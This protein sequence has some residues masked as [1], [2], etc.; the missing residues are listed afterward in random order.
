MNKDGT[1]DVT[2]IKGKKLYESLMVE[3]NAKLG[4]FK[5]PE[6]IFGRHE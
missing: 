6:H 3:A 5:M 4:L 2:Q 1:D